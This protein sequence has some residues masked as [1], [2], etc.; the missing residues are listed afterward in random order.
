MQADNPFDRALEIRKGIPD[1]MRNAAIYVTDT[2][3]LSWAAAQAVFG[4][5][6][7]PEHALKLLELFLIEDKSEFYTGHRGIRR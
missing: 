4:D 7:R 6:A 3:D 2:L 5:Q 1:S